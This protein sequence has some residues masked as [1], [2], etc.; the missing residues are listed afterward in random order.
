MQTRNETVGR[1]NNYSSARKR[2]ARAIVNN[3]TSEHGEQQH[4]GLARET[5]SAEV[6]KDRAG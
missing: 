1:V 4:G 2:N 3:N 6:E 5:I